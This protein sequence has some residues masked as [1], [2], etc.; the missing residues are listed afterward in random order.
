MDK[1]KTTFCLQQAREGV[2]PKEVEREEIPEDCPLKE[3]DLQSLQ[4][5][6]ERS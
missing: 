5:Q 4:K 2:H 1:N 6:T 3:V